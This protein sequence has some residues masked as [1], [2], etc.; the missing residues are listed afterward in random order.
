ML[1]MLEAI[2]IIIAVETR[3][4]TVSVDSRSTGGYSPP[5]RLC[6]VGRTGAWESRTL[7]VTRSSC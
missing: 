7:R 4:L 5:E 3:G 2:E 6:D 1:A